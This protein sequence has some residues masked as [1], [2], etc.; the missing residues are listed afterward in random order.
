MWLGLGWLEE[1]ASLLVSEL[2]VLVCD[3]AAGKCPL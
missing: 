3:M 1:E 2:Q